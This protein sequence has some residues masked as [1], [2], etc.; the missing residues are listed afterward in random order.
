MNTL[1]ADLR[2]IWLRWVQ[3]P[4][5]LWLVYLVV[6]FVMGGCVQLVLPFINIAYWARPWQF[7]TLYCFFLVPLSVL[8]RDLPWYRQYAYF[9]TAIMPLE[10]VAF[11]LHTSLAYPENILDPIVGIRNFT[12]T[13]VMIDSWIPWVGNRIVDFVW[14]RLG[15]REMAVHAS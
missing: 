6:Y 4:R 3:L 9:V 14:L 15:S 12:L 7:A 10:I 11:T 8:V 5:K 2:S 13:M 1:Y